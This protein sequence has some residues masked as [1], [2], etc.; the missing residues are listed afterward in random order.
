SSVI[1][2]KNLGIGCTL[3]IIK[4]REFS[5]FYMCESLLVNEL[6]FLKNI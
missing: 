2:D 1:D 4:T 5:L 6:E 3:I